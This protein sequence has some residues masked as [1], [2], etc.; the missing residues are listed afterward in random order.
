MVNASEPKFYILIFYMISDEMMSN[1]YVSKIGSLITQR[2]GEW[3]WVIKNKY[4]E[5]VS[6]SWRQKQAQ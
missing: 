6:K 1:F 2:G 3:E 4:Y 5:N